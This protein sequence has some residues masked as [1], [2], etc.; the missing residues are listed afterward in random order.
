MVKTIE[1]K[2][3]GFYREGELS[4]IKNHECAGVYVVYV[5]H[6]NPN[7]SIELQ[8]ILYIGRSTNVINRPSPSHH[9][10]DEWHTHLGENDLLYFSFA[11]TDDEELAEAA[12]IY[13]IKPVCNDTGK[14][15]FHHQETTIKNSGETGLL[16]ESFT[17]Q[18]TD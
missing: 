1:L 2:F 14:D 7:G 12:L 18:K 10:Y 4:T 15:G 8:C 13:K 5:G 6:H 17:V 11:D 3:D 9:K 16:G